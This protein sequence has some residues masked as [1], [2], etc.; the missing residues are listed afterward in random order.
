MKLSSVCVVGLMGVLASA[1]GTASPVAPTP[2]VQPGGAATITITSIA[3]A[4]LI[5][6]STLA[7]IT[8]TGTNFATGLTLSVVAPNMEK[9]MFAGASIQNL[10]VSSFQ[11][12]M[13]LPAAGSYS[14]QVVN[15]NGQASNSLSFPVQSGSTNPTITSIRPKGFIGSETDQNVILTGT[16][17]TSDVVVTIGKPNGDTLTIAGSHVTV[18]TDGTALQFDAVFDVSGSYSITVVTAA[19]SSNVIVMFVQ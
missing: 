1:C 14:A 19:G 17:L 16:G 15:L 7:V 6:S 5:Q 9:T 10:G 3:P 12:G 4:G 13:V 8:F 11:V 2:T 18:T